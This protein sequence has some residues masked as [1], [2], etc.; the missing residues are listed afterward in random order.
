M[1][2]ATSEVQGE[3]ARRPARLAALGV[4]T[5][6]DRGCGAAGAGVSGWA[7]TP[8]FEG[9]GAGSLDSERTRDLSTAPCRSVWRGHRVLF[10]AAALLAASQR[11]G[12]GAEGLHDAV[13]HLAGRG[14]PGAP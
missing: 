1:G 7:W 12:L 4:D 13:A 11:A 6:E 2:P 14:S 10:L 5:E 8:G 9:G 3:D